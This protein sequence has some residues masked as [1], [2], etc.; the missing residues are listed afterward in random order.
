MSGAHMSLG[1]PTNGAFV[2]TTVGIIGSG[3]LP[4]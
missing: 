3:W 2:A 1:A 4:L